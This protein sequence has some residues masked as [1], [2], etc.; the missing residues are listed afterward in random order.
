MSIQ[1]HKWSDE[2]IAVSVAGPDLI[3]VDV[4]GSSPLFPIIY[5]KSININDAIAIAKHFKLKEA[6]L[7]EVER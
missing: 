4:E 7:K 5:C 3:C 6:D 2:G 1:D